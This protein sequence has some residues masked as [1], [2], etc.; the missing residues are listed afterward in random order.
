[1][2]KSFITTIAYEFESE[3]LSITCELTV[4]ISNSTM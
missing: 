2:Y 4:D 1:M 3:G